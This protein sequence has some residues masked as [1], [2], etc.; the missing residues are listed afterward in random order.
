MNAAIA[1]E[2][3][4]AAGAD[5]FFGA[6]LSPAERSL[7]EHILL[8]AG[9]RR[10][11]NWREQLEQLLR[12]FRHGSPFGAK[13]GGAGG[14]KDSAQVG[15]LD[16][17]DQGN[18][19]P[20]LYPTSDFQNFDRYG[21]V[22]LGAAGVLT[23]IGGTVTN[24]VIANNAASSLPFFVPPG[25]NGFIKTMAAEVVANGGAAWTPGVLPPQVQLGLF[26]NGRQA[27]D[28]GQFFFSPAVVISPTPVAGIPIKETNLVQMFVTNKTLANTT[29]FVQARL[30]GYFYG[31]Q[32]EPKNLAF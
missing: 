7:W 20:W 21:T 32:F 31:K 10:G 13:S 4:L 5:P 12:Q 25:A 8:G 19:Y 28:Y 26:V 6:P 14:S 9:K 29:Q 24:N 22:A 2:R 23:S 11:W 1:I 15:T 27:F 30:Q 16:G 18:L 3:S 17:A